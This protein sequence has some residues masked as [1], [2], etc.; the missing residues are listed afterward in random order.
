MILSSCVGKSIH[1]RQEAYVCISAHT[2]VR[3]HVK[4][5]VC[6]CSRRVREREKEHRMRSQ[7]YSTCVNIYIHLSISV[8]MCAHP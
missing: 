6:A 2:H 1:R 5:C 4:G 7:V 3:S 8:Y